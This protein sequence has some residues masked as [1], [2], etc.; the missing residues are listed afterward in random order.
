MSQ[1]PAGVIPEPP[2]SNLEWARS[3]NE[4]DPRSP[5]P[6][7]FSIIAAPAQGVQRR[8][9][10]TETASAALRTERPSGNLERSS[11]AACQPVTCSWRRGLC[12][13]CGKDLQQHHRLLMARLLLL[14]RLT[15]LGPS[16]SSP[17][18]TTFLAQLGSEKPT[19]S[20]SSSAATCRVPAP[21]QR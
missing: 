20:S 15:R 4:A 12:H 21:T 16:G 10:P 6:P 18:E 1:Q 14:D 7:S 5:R 19:R 3:A 17:A 2:R 8:Q 13:G 11:R 9:K